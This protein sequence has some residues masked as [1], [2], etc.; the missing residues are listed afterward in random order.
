MNGVVP[1]TLYVA[2]QGEV[3]FGERKQLKELYKVIREEDPEDKLMLG[4]HP[5]SREWVL[6]LKPRANPFGLDA[7]YPVLGLGTEVPDPGEVRALLHKT[8]TRRNGSQIM[9]DIHANNNRIK[10]ELDAKA[11]EG[12][13]I[14]AD[15]QRSFLHRQGKAPF[16][17]SLPKRDPIHRQYSTR[18]DDD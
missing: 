17:Q 16:H 12:A 6:F 2:G 10:A 13:E 15:A 1:A 5:E 7:P 3:D 18:K 11:S 4:Q 8:D 9:D 14:L